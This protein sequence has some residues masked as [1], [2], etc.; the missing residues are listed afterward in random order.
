M[1]HRREVLELLDAY[2]PFP[3]EA[4]FK[5]RTIAFIKKHPE[6]FERSLSEGH[7]TASAWLLNKQGTKALLMHHAKLE[8]W[9]Q[10]GGHCDGNPSVLDVAIQE[11][12]EESGVMQIAPVS[13]AIF[14]LDIH[15]IPEKG[16]LKAHLHYDIRF[17]LQIVS[18]DAPRKNH[19]SKQLLWV[20]KGSSQL[21][22]DS[23]SVVRMFLKWNALS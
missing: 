2:V 19:E 13:R 11:A 17:L 4:L 22:T 3:E 5:E 18:G 8:M 6:C 9:V 14:D 10:L 20:D 12:Q 15:E 1:S 7:I 21:P 23:R 16:G